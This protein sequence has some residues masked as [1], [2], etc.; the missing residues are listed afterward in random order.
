[1]D[2]IVSNSDTFRNHGFYSILF[3]EVAPHSI[4]SDLLG[5]DYSDQS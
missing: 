1:M 5:L 3:G 2:T 4:P